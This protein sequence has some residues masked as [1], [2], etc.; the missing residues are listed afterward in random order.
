MPTSY[1]DIL[2]TIFLYFQPSCFV[3]LKILNFLFFISVFRIIHFNIKGVFCKLHYKPMCDKDTTWKLSIVIERNFLKVNIRNPFLIHATSYLVHIWFCVTIDLVC[4]MMQEVNF[5]FV[6]K[7]FNSVQNATYL[8]I[9]ILS[10]AVI[11]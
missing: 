11:S 2:F 8:S 6:D 4:W 7:R 1:V 9:Y 10:L 5:F 3:I